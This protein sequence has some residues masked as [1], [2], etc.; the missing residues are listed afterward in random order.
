MTKAFEKLSSRE[1]Q[2]MDIIYQNGT[3]TV[4][5]VQQ[6]IPD[7]PNY[8]SVRAILG[9]LENKGFVRHKKSGRAFVYSPVIK[10]K[11]ASNQML[12]QVVN[13]FFDGSVE[14]VVAALISMKSSKL[15][16]DDFKR[17]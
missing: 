5:E 6:A 8:S 13:T 15:S 7:S 4:S 1:R 17:L 16:E 12:K 9:I 14:N 11:Q 2:I 10:R 3:A